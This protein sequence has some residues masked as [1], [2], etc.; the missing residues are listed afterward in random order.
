MCVCVCVCVCLCV[1]KKRERDFKE[2]THMI[3]EADKPKICRL[4]Q[5]ARADVAF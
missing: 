1:Q 3:V 4:G 2:L 5:Q